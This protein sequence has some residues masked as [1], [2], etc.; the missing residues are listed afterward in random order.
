RGGALRRMRIGQIARPVPRTRDPAGDAARGCKGRAASAA[1]EVVPCAVDQPDRVEEGEL[2]EPAVHGRA[3]G[4]PP[5]VG[6]I[7]SKRTD[8]DAELV[9]GCGLEQYGVELVVGG[10]AVIRVA[11]WRAVIGDADAVEDAG[12]AAQRVPE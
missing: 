3:S 8:A 6:E 4:P 5:L 9:V 12:N 1:R 7:A 2:E 11:G 10:Q